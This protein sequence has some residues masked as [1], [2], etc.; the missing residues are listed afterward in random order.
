[1]GSIFSKGDTE[2]RCVGGSKRPEAAVRI[3]LQEGSKRHIPVI[4][5]AKETAGY[6]HVGWLKFGRIDRQ[7]RAILG[8]SAIISQIADAPELGYLVNLFLFLVE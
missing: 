8:A 5:F 1:L 4:E 3:N 7:E 2:K 6:R